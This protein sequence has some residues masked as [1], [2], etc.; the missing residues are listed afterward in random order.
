[1]T[2]RRL[3]EEHDIEKAGKIGPVGT[4]FTLVKG[5]VA[6]GVLFLP[7]G[8]RNGGWMFSSA[9]LIMSCI[10]SSI[11]WL[12]LLQV[13]KKYKLSFSE[14]GYKAFGPIGKFAVDFF[15]AVSQ[16]LFVW[17]YITFIWTTVNTILDEQLGLG[18]NKQMDTR[19]LLI[20]NLCSTYILHFSI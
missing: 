9:S 12:M 18:K 20:C 16:T 14:I 11:C 17:A 5:F 10:F 7:K 15:L 1:M 8:W 3:K 13:R 2:K 4:F 19:S 6:T